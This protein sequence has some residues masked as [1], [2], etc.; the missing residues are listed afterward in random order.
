[1]RRRD[2]GIGLVEVLVTIMLLSIA[3]IGTAGEIAVYLKQQ[4]IEN[5][6]TVANHLA[7]SWFEY[8]ESLQRATD[9]NTTPGNTASALN[10]PAEVTS[11]T[12]RVLS[13]SAVV[14]GVTY[15]QTVQAR[16][17]TPAQLAVPNFALTS[18]NGSVSKINTIYSTIKIAWE[19]GGQ[20]HSLT[21]TRNLADDSTY[22]PPNTTDPGG[23]ALSNCTRALAKDSTTGVVTNLVSSSLEMTPVTQPNFSGALGRVTV[24]G[25]TGHPA[26]G[27]NQSTLSGPVTVTLKETGLVN[28]ED[29]T[30]AGFGAPTCVPLFWTDSTGTHQIDLHT[31]SS[32]TGA[33][34]DTTGN[35]LVTKD[36]FTSKSCWYTGTVPLSAITQSPSTLT[37]AN[38]WDA[39]IPFCAM[40]LGKLTTCP[41]TNNTTDNGVKT[42][43]YVNLA[44]SLSCTVNGGVAI[45]R[46]LGKTLLA[47]QVNCSAANVSKTDSLVATLPTGATMNLTSSNGTAWSGSL[48]AG[49]T[50][51]GGTNNW[52]F[53]ITRSTAGEDGNS[54]TITLPVTALL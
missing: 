50:Y 38:V 47:S 8:A 25:N 39:A 28:N 23:N 40:L 17:C 3:L 35:D 46:L 18:C 41:A 32:G 16:I 54:T 1:L 37:A 44:P 22:L 52:T 4:K 24:D 51:P 15:T 10:L 31:A 27:P 9:T 21:V 29:K 33:C 7:D 6:Q 42:N 34:N 11:T 5:S 26:K 43:L 49:T 48:A 45:T 53:K 19:V 14:N 12:P 36:N 20:R 30:K 13:P 2:P